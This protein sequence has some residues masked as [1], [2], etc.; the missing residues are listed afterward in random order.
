M[1]NKP[2]FEEVGVHFPFSFIAPC[3]SFLFPVLNKPTFEEVGIHSP[4]SF[5]APWTI[6]SLPPLKLTS[7]SKDGKNDNG[8]SPTT[9][10]GSIPVNDWGGKII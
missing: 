5:I 8:L 4:F 2:S 9:E 10:A 6:Q 3:T 7:S 1:V